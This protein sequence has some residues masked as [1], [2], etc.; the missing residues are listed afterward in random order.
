MTTL[1]SLVSIHQYTIVNTPFNIH[2]NTVY[3]FSIITLNHNYNSDVHIL[4]Q[5]FIYKVKMDI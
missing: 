3:N 4:I 5:M 2:S 1:M